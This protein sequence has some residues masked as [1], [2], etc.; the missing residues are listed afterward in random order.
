MRLGHKE[1]KGGGGEGANVREPATERG[2]LKERFSVGTGTWWLG[3]DGKRK[4]KE[5][6]VGLSS[7]CKLRSE[8]ESRNV[9]QRGNEDALTC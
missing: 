4:E 3:V 8:R 2:G 5:G 9:A 6:A 7:N 1:L